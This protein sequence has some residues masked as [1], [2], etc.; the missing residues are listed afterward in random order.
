MTRKNILVTGANGPLGARVASLLGRENAVTG[1]SRNLA[2]VEFTGS[3]KECDL[4]N[5]GQVYAALSDQQIVVHAASSVQHPDLD[6]EAQ[7]N[8]IDA[9]RSY[10]DV[11]IVYVS[12]CGIEEA[13]KHSLYYAMKI[14]NEQMLRESG[15][16]HTII[17]ISQFHPFVS[18]ILSNLV[19]GPFLLIPKLTLQSVDLDFAANQ[20]ASVALLPAQGRAPDVHGPEVLTLKRM[21]AAWTQARG[22]KKI[23]VPI[24]AFGAL[25]GFA[26]ITQVAGVTGGPTWT[27]WLASSS[28]QTNPYEEKQL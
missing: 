7:Q 4:S 19:R 2:P 25:K 8:L 3:W 14:K 28:V 18:S 21:A 26:A 22:Y 11:H 1:L 17:R 24:P 9:V 5:R 27:Q 23:R 20:L 16:A 6:V 15:V 12:I 10:R 13:A